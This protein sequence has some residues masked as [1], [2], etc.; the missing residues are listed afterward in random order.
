M[1]LPTYMKWKA[2]FNFGTTQLLGDL[3][4][5]RFE[6]NHFLK[7]LDYQSTR[8]GLGFGIE[9]T[10]KNEKFG[11]SANVNYIRLYGNDKYSDEKNRRDRNLS[12]MTNMYACE[13]RLYYAPFQNRNIRVYTGVGGFIFDPT[14]RYDGKV[15]HLRK[16]GTEGQLLD[17]GKNA[18][19]KFS[20]SI[21]LGMQVKVG[22]LSRGDYEFWID[23]CLHKCFTDYLDDVS[24]TY[25]DNNSIM[26]QNGVVAAKLA[27][28]SHSDIP[29]FSSKGA[30]RGDKN[31]KDN[32]SCLMFT[33]KRAVHFKSWDSDK[34]GISNYL[35]ICKKTPKG[36]DVDS[37]GCYNDSDDD[38]VPD[39]RDQ[40]PHVIGHIGKRGCPYEDWDGD[41]ISNESDSCVR[42]AGSAQLMGCP[43]FDNDGVADK[44][45]KCPKVVGLA[46]LNGC[47]DTDG[48]GVPDIEDKCPNQVGKIDHYGCPEMPQSASDSIDMLMK[49]IS[50]NMGGYEIKTENYQDLFEV[51]KI[52]SNYPNLN[53]VVEGHADSVG[54]VERNKVISKNRAD[55]IRDFLIRYGLDP[56]HISTN[57]LDES[58]P[59]ANNGPKTR[60]RNR[61]VEI[62]FKK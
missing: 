18:Y 5:N 52:L 40:C 41:G 31:Y 51:V 19:S 2:S 12:V 50:F 44:Y 17:G 49:R 13:L 32:Y 9:N 35:D 28:R 3:G 20:Y 7:D 14:A 27:D 11:F 34:D 38:G 57:G 62:K 29:G 6:A 10:F 25:A 26:A 53:I 15:Y 4:G 46:N 60:A 55:A 42:V 16:L 1:S 21:P 23:L 30:I 59:I 33:I 39:H 36:T 22:S 48:D 37:N 43:D 47:P 61:R 45:D 54:T 56:R 8:Y 24:S 58:K